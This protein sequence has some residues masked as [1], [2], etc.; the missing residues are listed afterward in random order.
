MKG[1][2][3][4]V[5]AFFLCSNFVLTFSREVFAMKEKI[6]RLVENVNEYYEQEDRLA[7]KNSAYSLLVTLPRIFWA[8]FSG[9]GVAFILFGM[10]VSFMGYVWFSV[11]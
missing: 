2:D 6:K 11:S 10:L 3:N 5:V 8:V 9:L 4:L 7:E 1:Y